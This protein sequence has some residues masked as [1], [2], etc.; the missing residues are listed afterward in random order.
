MNLSKIRLAE[1]LGKRG[2]III[3]EVLVSLSEYMI[4][5]IQSG[6]GAL[7]KVIEILTQ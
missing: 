1:P 6:T 5:D 7:R 3:I 2:E 4:D